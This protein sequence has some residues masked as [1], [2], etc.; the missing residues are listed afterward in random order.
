MGNAP[1]TYFSR[2]GLFIG[3][4]V[5]IGFVVI[6]WIG[7]NNRPTSVDSTP[8]DEFSGE[9]KTGGDTRLASLLWTTIESL[10]MTNNPA[11]AHWQLAELRDFLRTLPPKTAATQIQ[12]FLNSKTNVA[13][14]LPFRIGA[15]G[16]LTD[17][18]TLRVF[19]LD[20]LAQIDPVAAVEYA[21]VILASIDSPDEWAIALRNYAKGDA[22]PQGK[23][24]L[25]EKLRVMLTYEPWLQNPSVGYLETFDVA[26]HVGG[27]TLLPP[28]TEILRLPDQPAAAR[29]AY[30]ALD[31]M[32]I[33]QPTEILTVLNA[34]PE[35][36]AGREQTRA[37]YFA[38]LDLGN[39][40][41]RQIAETYLLNS[42]RTESELQAFAGVFP[43]ANYM[44]SHNL[45]TRTDTPDGNTLLRRD[46]EALEVVNNWLA[47]PHFEKLQSDLLRIKMRLSEFVRQAEASQRPN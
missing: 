7:R 43:N 41:Q 44:I 10:Q 14:H 40:A 20:Y 39:A 45:L 9:V 33:Q 12:D 2:L 22:T 25:E 8:K 30:L 42:E 17:A 36:M 26:V 18:P 46:R 31:R 21:K 16:F 19:L 24:F 37:N 4:P 15:D 3:L 27:P 28:L 34:Q 13:T 23:S 1:K 29:A 11:V 5:L 6:I 35:L 47:D 32:V 38:R